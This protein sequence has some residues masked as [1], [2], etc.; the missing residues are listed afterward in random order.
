MIVVGLL[1]WLAGPLDPRLPSALASTAQQ[2]A[3]PYATQSPWYL[4]TSTP[5]PYGANPNNPYQ[6][7]PTATP[8]GYGQFPNQGGASVQG[9]GLQYPSGGSLPSGSIPAAGGAPLPG[10]VQPGVGAPSPGVVSDPCYGDELITYSPEM[11]RVGND[12]LIAVTSS[13]PHPYGRLAGTE[14]VQFSR[15]RPGQRGYVW[16]WLV[17]PTYPGQHTYTFYVDSTIPCQTVQFAVRDQL[18]TRTPTPTRT[19]KPYYWNTSSNGNS[20]DNGDD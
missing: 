2:M 16:E 19:P 5:T 13:R 11:P 8:Y 14:R 4:Q 1:A 18:S 6:A 9:G 3:T 12:L 7:T 10:A 17:Q 20:N 15:E